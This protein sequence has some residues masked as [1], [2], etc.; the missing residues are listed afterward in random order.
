LIVWLSVAALPF[1]EGNV[2]SRRHNGWYSRVP[3]SLVAPLVL[4]L[5]AG[6]V[7]PSFTS[8]AA[9]A[10]EY[11]T[12]GDVQQA[13]GSE[14]VTKTL[15]T[16]LRSQID[17]LKAEVARTA[18]TAKAKGAVYEEA[19][20]KFQEAALKTGR[21]QGLADA[22]EETA[23]DSRLR[24]GQIAAQLARTG[25]SDLTAR[26]FTDAG[27]ADNLLSRL[28]VAHKVTDLSEAMYTKALQDQNTAQ[29]FADQAVVAKAERERLRGVA[30]V[31]LVAAQVSADAADAAL[32]AEVE[33]RAVLEAQLSVL[34][35]RR[36]ATESD[37]AAGE[38]ARAAEAAVRKAASGPA[39]QVAKSGWATPTSGRISGGYGYGVDPVYGTYRLHTGTD[40]ADGCNVPIYAA[41]A[42]RVAYSGLLGTYGNWI[43]IDHGNGIQTGYAHIID[44]GRLVIAGQEVSAGQMIARTGATGKSTGCHLHFEV[45]LN[46]Q[47][48]DAVPFMRD[49]GVILG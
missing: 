45:R 20:R 28:G 48:T 17:G 39:G 11:P 19:D 44:G 27:N 8:D 9:F 14:S 5:V 12:W 3:R 32:K 36:E 42:G 23:A 4:A 41:T 25:G 35:E 10:A 13:R 1:E 18:D 31:A 29:G 6:A 26:L 40:I 37:Y 7:A 30:V 46:D 47:A 34:T 15:I 43:L 16:E 49:R 21:L 22:A 2:I 38:A 33:H 24:A